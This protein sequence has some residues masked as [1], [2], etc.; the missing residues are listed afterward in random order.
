M[1]KVYGVIYKATNKVTGKSYIGRTTMS[2][3][4]R[5]RMHINNSLNIGN[6]TYFHNAIRKHGQDNFKWKI[7]A[8]C[9]SKEELNNVEIEMIE[10]Y[11]TLKNGYNLSL[12]GS[13]NAGYKHTKEVIEKR[14]KMYKG[15][16]NNFYGKHHSDEAKKK[17]SESRK[18]KKLSVEIKQKLRE[19]STG[20]KHTKESIKKMVDLKSLMWIIFFP[21]GNKKVIKN[22]KKFCGD[23]NLS[24]VCMSDVAKGRQK[25]Y[26][27][28]KCKRLYE[29]LIICQN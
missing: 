23:N 25:H 13:S 20:K 1:F 6:N 26:K 10:K 2:L 4:R 7:I 16:G 28:Y 15:K 14:S 12:G 29:E 8:K 17:I 5:I 11:N 3:N 19:I 22:L 9:F 24:N 18:G 27:G 21:N